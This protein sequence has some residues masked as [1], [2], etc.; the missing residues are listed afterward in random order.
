MKKYLYSVIAFLM[1]AMLSTSAFS[2]PIYIGF[3]LGFK[4]E[5]VITLGNCKDGRGICLSIGN[6]NISDNAQI[7]FD[8]D[9]NSVFYLKVEKTSETGKPFS[10]GKFIV[11]VDSPI[12]PALIAK[13]SEFK[14]P[15]KKIVVIKKG[16]YQVKTEGKFYI[17]ELN[18]YLQ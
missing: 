13:F 4:A 16:T 14:N 3:R 8:Q 18:Y 11:E 1:L 17:V 15:N 10:S 12:D 5:W 2:R 7:G 9:A 6:P